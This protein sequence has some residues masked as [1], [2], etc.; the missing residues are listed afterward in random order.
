MKNN[1]H[2]RVSN[3]VLHQSDYTAAE[4]SKTKTED[5]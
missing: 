3:Q 5:S 2:L 4:D 1:I